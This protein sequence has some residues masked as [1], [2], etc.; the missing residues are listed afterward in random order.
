VNLPRLSQRV[1]DLFWAPRAIARQ[2]LRVSSFTYAFWIG[3][4][5]GGYFILRYSGQWAE[6]DSVAFSGITSNL[7]LY[8]SFS[9]EINPKN[10]PH[11]YAFPVWMASL[12]YLTGLPVG[13]LMRWYTPMVGN[14]FLAMFGFC[15]YRRWLGSDRLGLLAASVL[16]L[17]PEM[18]FTV[19]RGNHEKITVSL[20]LLASLALLKS[21]LEIQARN[22]KLF[23]S[24][25]TVYYLVS[26]TL[27]SL[28]VLFGSSFIVA[29]TLTVIVAWVFLRFRPTQWGIIR[30]PLERLTLRIATSWLLVLIVMWYIYPSAGENFNLL[31]TAVEKLSTLFL[32][33]TPE[34]NPYVQDADPWASVLGYRLISSFRWILF[35]ISFLTWLLL[36][37]PT[38][39][40]NSKA[41]LTR[42]FLL[43]LY[44]A[45]GFQLAVAIPV[46]LIGL[47]AGSNLQVR[48][49]VYF[50]LFA[51][52]VFV[53]GV[54][55]LVG[56]KS[57][58][59][60]AVV[61][62][63]FGF[64]SAIKATLDP[65]ISN[66][67]MQYTHTE[68]QAIRTWAQYEENS[69]LYLG[70]ITR[71]NDAWY[72]NYGLGLPGG[73]N[74]SINPDSPEVPHALFSSTQEANNS[75][76]RFRLPLL[77]L[78]NRVYDNGDTQIYH[79]LP[80]TPFQR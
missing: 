7:Q 58:L 9:Q 78:D 32:S 56:P 28:N 6:I 66:L 18:V 74:L 23:A 41:P 2:P 38:I 63:G 15:A 72:M 39:F 20:T 27:S 16:F 21:F 60:V 42:V 64:L 10:Y 70:R 36:L 44:G 22:W 17:V 31:K 61:M 69:L 49:Y 54:T 29:S 33:F 62:A 53:L 43:A 47:E 57:R 3:L 79:R 52:P 30:R 67:W 50:V 25:L 48:M 26:F 5:F 73:N 1:Q 46:D 71:L 45:F 80:R 8:G 68:L 51:A 75:A 76:W 35:A 14:L 37:A 34:S 11:G 40:R 4:A 65:H 24:W 59:I 77:L 12:S 13:E 55:R 19:S